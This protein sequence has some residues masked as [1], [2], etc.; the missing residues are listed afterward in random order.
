LQ[1]PERIAMLQNV[2]YVVWIN[3]FQEIANFDDTAVFQKQLVAQWKSHNQVGYLFCGSKMN[4]MRE[5]FDEK[6]PFY[7]F[8]EEIKIEPID[9]KLFADYIVRSFSKSGRVISKEFAEILCRKVKHYPFYVQQF[10]HLCWL[11]TKGFVIDSMM[12]SATEELLNYNERLFRLQVDNLSLSQLHYLQAIIDDIDRFSSAEVIEKYD[13][14][15]SANITRVREALKKKE[16]IHFFRNK[17]Y[18]IDP[19]FELWLRTRYFNN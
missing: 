14:H 9:E 12:D 2:S 5:L 18:F 17:P 19:V 4:A 8:C 10:A 1:L 13:L 6:Q 7:K 16:I 11:N 15:S 3:E